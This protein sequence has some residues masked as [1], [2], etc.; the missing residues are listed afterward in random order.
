MNPI[1]RQDLPSSD[2]AEIQIRN[3]K[4]SLPGP[5][6]KLKRSGNALAEAI[7]VMRNKI[8]QKLICYQGKKNELREK[9]TWKMAG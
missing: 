5:A 2:Q 9:Q 6:L 4:S 1:H 8:Q 3:L 7:F